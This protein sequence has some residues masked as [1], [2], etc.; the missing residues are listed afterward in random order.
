MGQG[1]L[2]IKGEGRAGQGRGLLLSSSGFVL[3]A[4]L[5]LLEESDEVDD[6]V[7]DEN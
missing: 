6:G 1:G 7:D 3:A 2:V 4:T 5:P